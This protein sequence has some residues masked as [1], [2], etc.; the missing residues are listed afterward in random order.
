MYQ[1]LNIVSTSNCLDISRHDVAAI[2]IYAHCVCN[3]RTTIGN[4]IYTNK[5]VCEYCIYVRA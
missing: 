3:I 5:I 2:L 4:K 1:K